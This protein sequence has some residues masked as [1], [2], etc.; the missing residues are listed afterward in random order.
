MTI[1]DTAKYD[2]TMNRKT[3]QSITATITIDGR[4]VIANCIGLT[5][6]P[7]NLHVNQFVF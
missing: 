6:Q 3:I 1:P 4:V 5:K 7:C 2:E